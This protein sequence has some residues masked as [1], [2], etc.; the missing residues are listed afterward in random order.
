M[1]YTGA[2]K[3]AFCQ[4][5]GA[6]WVELA[7][8]VDIPPHERQGFARGNEARAIWEWLERRGR[9]GILPPALRA[10]G[11]L[12]L[13]DLLAADPAGTDSHAERCDI[14]ADLL[15]ERTLDYWREQ[16][17]RRRIT[18]PAPAAVRWGWVFEASSPGDVTAPPPAGTGPL[19]A[20]EAHPGE[21]D[22]LTSGV[23]TRLHEEVYLRLPHRRLAI[24]GGAGAGKT[25]A[26]IL[27]LLAALDHRRHLAGQ[28]RASTPVPVWL[29]VGGWN[30]ATT[31]VRAWA[32]QTINRDHPYLR[33]KEL[34]PDAAGDLLRAGRV[35][36]FLDGLDEAPAS[37]RVQM[38]ERL[39]REASGLCVVMTSRTD[40]FH[41]AWA[42]ERLD[43][44]AVIE[45]R[46]VRPRAAADYLLRDQAGPQR[47]R[48]ARVCAHLEEHPDSPAAR[49]LDNPLT[50]S[51]ARDTY[52]HDDPVALVDA[53]SHTTEEELRGRL[54]ARFLALAYPDP[55]ERDKATSRL[56]WIAC[57]MGTNRD[58]S[59]WQIP[60]WIPT[61]QIRLTAGLAVGLAHVLTLWLPLGLVI[62]HE[63]GFAVG[64]ASVPA[65]G[66]P[67]GLAF[68]LSV[69]L[70]VGLGKESQ[71]LDP[72]WPR[73]RE[74]LRILAWGLAFGFPVWLGGIT[75]GWATD[76]TLPG[77]GCA[78]GCTIGL[79]KLWR[80]PGARSSA[81]TPLSTYV[82][83]WHAQVLLGLAVGLLV[84]LS[85]WLEA[86]LA[87]GAGA[88]LAVGLVL[89]LASGL[90]VGL[91]V[92]LV[93]GSASVLRLTEIALLFQGR[94]QGRFMRLLK[95]ALDRQLLRQT[96][97]VYQFRHAE[98][99]DHL[100]A[101]H[102]Q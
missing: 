4:R 15:A 2:T 99:Q 89:G 53:S 38:L 37:T 88:G 54:L 72:R 16:A 32:G 87:L 27:L 47:G 24:L 86:G 41:D 5:L 10:L 66:L 12:D 83:D 100:A 40:Q 60:T 29:T 52:Q 80:A 67:V 84:G 48:W 97:A 49:A 46:P 61:W 68:G 55:G 17:S 45:L 77:I 65:F 26:M 21:A 43:N 18:T 6:D 102:R 91:V 81:A 31:S 78:I 90:P 94:S 33:A 8:L 9:L 57:H 19:P 13:V 25:A 69:G 20:A 64:L 92:G 30:P 74:T 76:F 7:D 56:A 82:L 44:T 58:L 39:R 1:A 79:A 70:A 34:G 59:W 101:R 63:R 85:T 93:V 22:V 75:S 50:L 96:G 3:V 11:R 35:A 28:Q 95:V 36:L 73:W 51:L 71:T 98:L 42:A 62:G 23:V 14:A